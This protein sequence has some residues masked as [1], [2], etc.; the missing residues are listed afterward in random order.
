MDAGRLNR[1]RLVRV[2]FIKDGATVRTVLVE[3][4]IADDNYMAIKSGISAGR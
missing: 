2:I 4:G 1:K 3:S